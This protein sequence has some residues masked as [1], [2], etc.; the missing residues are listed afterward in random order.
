MFLPQEVIR[1][2]R[3]SC[4]ERRRNSLF[5]NGI[6]DNSV[7]EGQ[8]AVQAMDIFFHN[9]TL[10]GGVGDVTSL[11]LGPMGWPAAAMS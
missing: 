11:M 3:R 1:K 2:K 6:C 4:V 7:S 8:I 9:M 5:I 10:T